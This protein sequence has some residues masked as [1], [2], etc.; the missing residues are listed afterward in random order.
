MDSGTRERI[1]PD[2]G[3]SWPVDWSDL[4]VGNERGHQK[5][6]CAHGDAAKSHPESLWGW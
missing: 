6:R 2:I 4:G 1:T 5:C 3:G